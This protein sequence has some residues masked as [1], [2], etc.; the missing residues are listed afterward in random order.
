[1]RSGTS[2]YI[3]ACIAEIELPAAAG[4]AVNETRKH[5]ASVRVDLPVLVTQGPRTI[6]VHNTEVGVGGW[7]EG[8]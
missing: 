5:D 8:Q 3:R 2:L 1:M 6:Y 7:S 4:R